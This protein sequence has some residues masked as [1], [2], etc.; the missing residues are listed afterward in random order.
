MSSETVLF[1]ALSAEVLLTGL[2][3]VTARNLIRSAFWLMPCFLGVACLFLLLDNALLFTVQLLIYAGA[4]PILI[5][6][7]LMLTREVMDGQRKEQGRLWPLGLATALT[8]LLFALP[9]VRSVP[10]PPSVGPVPSGL[11][12]AI[13]SGFLNGYVLPFEVASLLLVGALV[14]AVYLAHSPKRTRIPAPP[15]ELLME[16][17]DGGDSAPAL[18]DHSHVSV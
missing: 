7:V 5:L 15:K 17:S 1:Y 9:R 16:E 18:A 3:V 14:G 11:T 12:E 8:F 6:F 4:V 10:E 13:G 2:A